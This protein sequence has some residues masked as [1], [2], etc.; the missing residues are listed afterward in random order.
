MDTEEQIKQIKETIRLLE[1]QLLILKE[2]LPVK[3]DSKA[4]SKHTGRSGSFSPS[5]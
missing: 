2:S 4:D 5:Y 3:S 1:Y